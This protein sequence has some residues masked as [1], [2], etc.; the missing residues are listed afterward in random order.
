VDKRTAAGLPGLEIEAW[1]LA[2]ERMVENPMNAKSVRVILLAIL[3]SAAVVA[4]AAPADKKHTG[5]KTYRD[6]D[7]GF[8]IAYPESMTFY[9]GHPVEPMQRAMF[10]I[11]DHTIACF[12]Y[13]GNALDGTPTNTIGL[14][15]NIVRGVKTETECINSTDPRLD[16]IKTTR[17]RGTPFHYGET[18]DAGLGSGRSM[19]EYLAFYQHVC[20][21]VALGT[22]GRNL[23]TQ[24]LNDGGLHPVSRRA[25]R[26]IWNDMDR[27]LH[28][29]TFVGPVRDGPDWDVYSDSY[30]GHSFEY[31]SSSTVQQ[32][33]KVSNEA[34]QSSRIT[35]E[36][37]FAYNGREYTV[38]V[39]VNLKDE[40][41]ANKWLLASGY[42]A[43]D[44]MKIVA[45][46]DD[47]TE[48][49][50]Q[51]HTYIHFHNDLFI[52]TVS[53]ANHQPIPSGGDCVFAHLLE[54]FR[55]R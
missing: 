52:F 15:V 4:W 37:A 40:N 12:L 21:D 2:N 18:G 36:Q 32:V 41:A 3:F 46:E 10:P 43:L 16:P 20:F 49:S 7:Y 19:T 23:G 30:C 8:T 13:N 31:P 27:M 55:A 28:S 47:F 14:S 33:L 6:P 26:K 48:Y 38:A 5:W 17:I 11:C 50:D 54:S 24:D 25:Y 51:T 35:C 22:A 42:P 1:G 34:F 44:G 29:F 9:P 53:G 45:K 39:K